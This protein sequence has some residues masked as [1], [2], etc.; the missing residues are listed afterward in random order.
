MEQILTVEEK[1]QIID[2]YEKRLEEL[3]NDVRTVGWSSRESQWLRFQVLTRGLALQGRTILDIGCGLGDLVVFLDQQTGGDYRYLGI[4]I[5]P[6]LI[7]RAATLHGGGNRAFR[8]GDLLQMT[9]VEPADLVLMSGAL[10]FRVSDNMALAQSMLRRMYALT[11]E[12]MAVNFLSSHVDY[13]LEKNFHY[14]PS[15]IFS[16]AKKL[17]PWVALWHDYPL[18]EFTLQLHTHSRSF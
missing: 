17:T 8:T 9:D 2:L 16:F 10:T 6:R 4:D 15:Q 12:S 18:W 13:Q 1:K 11:R 14:D 3:G 7:D 5:S